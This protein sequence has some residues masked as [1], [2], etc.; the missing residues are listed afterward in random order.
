IDIEVVLGVD[1][2]DAEVGSIGEIEAL[3][4]R[5]DP[6]DIG[7]HDRIAWNGNDTEKADRRV[8]V[9]LVMLVVPA[10]AIIATPGVVEIRA[11]RQGHDDTQGHEQRSN[12]SRVHMTS[13]AVG[14]SAGRNG[15]ALRFLVRIRGVWTRNL[16]G[17]P[18]GIYGRRVKES[19]GPDK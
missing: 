9:V 10:V 12:C 17:K 15:R 18:C 3:R 5:I 14:K 7:A 1:D 19:I 13:S 4:S 16:R 11:N 2:V 6:A 8:H